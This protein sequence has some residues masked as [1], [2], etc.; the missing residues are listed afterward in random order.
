MC[1]TARSSASP[2]RR[3]IFRGWP[4]DVILCA[5]ME[6]HRVLRPAA[7]GAPLIKEKLSVLTAAR[8]IITHAIVPR[9]GLTA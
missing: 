4:E 6:S 3:N 7:E 5:V 2:L 8:L 9:D 1:C